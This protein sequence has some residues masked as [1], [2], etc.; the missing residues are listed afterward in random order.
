M[1]LGPILGS[2]LGSFGG[3]ALGGAIGGNTGR[4]IGSLAGSMLGGQGL[5]RLGS[6][7]G[8]LGGLGRNKTSSPSQG[9]TTNL[10]HDGGLLPAEGH[11]DISE[12]HAEVLLRAMCFAAKSDGSVDE[13]EINAIMDRLGE[14]GAEEAALLRRELSGPVDLDA[15]LE[16]VPSGLEEEVY[17]VSLLAIDA[18]SGPEA[19]YLA[20]L[21]AGLNLSANAVSRMNVAVS[22]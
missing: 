2:L 7:F 13:Q 8:G 19:A 6:M 3:R 15:L 1:R 22:A 11:E 16:I 20:K 21:A 18:V 4:M 10:A 17:A 9:Q 14:V 12:A 5:S